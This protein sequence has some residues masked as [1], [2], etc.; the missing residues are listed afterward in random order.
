MNIKTALLYGI[1]WGIAVASCTTPQKTTSTQ[2][3]TA[4]QPIEGRQ[5][6]LEVIEEPS[7]EVSEYRA[8]RT[9]KFDLIHTRLEVSFD[10]EN[11]RMPGKATLQLRPYFYEQDTLVLDAKGFDISAVE[12]VNGDVTRDA[13]YDYD[14]LELRVPLDR[15]YTRKETLTLKVDYTAKPYE[16]EIG[17]SAA[18]TED[19]GLYFINHDGADPEKPRQIWTQGETEA[20]SCWFPTI[21]APNQRSTQ[22]IYITVDDNFTTLSNGD[23]V[24]SQVNGDGTRTDYWKMDSSH[25]PYLFMM[26]VGEYAVVEDEWNGVP[27]NYYV[28]PAYKDYAK[29]IFGNT[30]EMMTYF[31]ELLDYPYPWSKYSQIV[32]R[33]Y[34]SGAMENT[35]ASVYMED[36]Q[37]TRRELLDESYEYIIAH[38]LFH[39]W[40]GDLVTCESW[41]NLTLNEGFASYSEYLW[42]AYK[43]GENAAQNK[44]Y[45]ELNTYLSEAETKKEDLIR[46]YY[47]DREEMF[48]S[49]SYA[50]GGL[51][52]HML[53]DY[54]G[55]D[56]FFASLS[57]YLK[58]NKFK[59]VEVHHLRLAFEEITGEDLNW[60]FNQWFLAKGHPVLKVEH[61][62]VDSLSLLHVSV[63]QIQDR[64]EIP[65]YRVPVDVEIWQGNTREH[66]VLWVDKAENEYTFS[67]SQRPSL[68][69][70]NSDED[71]VAEVIHK[72]DNEELVFQA[73]NAPNAIARLKA[74]EILATDTT[75]EMNPVF[76]RGLSDSFDDIKRISIAYAQQDPQLV[77]E[78][79]EEILKL[80][81]KGHDTGV[82]SDA[83]F[84]LYEN[85]G[86][87]YSELYTEAANDSSYL[88]AGTGLHVM[89]QSLES[90]EEMDT[91]IGRFLDESNINIVLP[92][93][94]H[95][96]G[97]RD[98]T[99][100]DWY[101]RQLKAGGVEAK[102]YL[103]RMLGQY[104]IVSRPERVEDGINL[105]YQYAKNDPRYY[106]RIAALQS[107]Q[108][109]E[110]HELARQRLEELKAS[111]TDERV[112][113]FLN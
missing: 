31:S 63:S 101:E 108:F 17:G 51:I 8:E 40:F 109:F 87:K 77:D 7:G 111:E 19:R 54:V 53:R 27:V 44:L 26:A 52:L 30:P 64:N 75:G 14:G 45:Q 69:L 107:L 32:V 39:H 36:V 83:L 47:K 12:I 106:L 48:D 89:L 34:V 57:H 33:D 29:D 5:Q 41:S 24:Y 43:Y 102:Y 95:F 62:Y 22:E 98:T 84:A 96:I 78:W 71:I 97:S 88:V 49:H 3:T 76:H 68:F 82:R 91:L 92:L 46:F 103:L 55:D 6:S 99:R 60:F 58:K 20:N 16:R 1:I 100:Y 80:T 15:K 113:R 93:A 94:S 9:K 21:D 56:A 42:E 65:I 23:L 25:A 74:Y 13:R 70:F 4:E 18:I 66:Q 67:V 104:V 72:K 73:L 110:D 10:W 90:Q 11:R 50:K 112:K 2:T 105:L 86:P 81:A 61:S 38:E 85:F 37:L 28:E 79:E 35:T 59:D